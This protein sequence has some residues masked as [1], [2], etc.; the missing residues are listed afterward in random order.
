M[1]AKFQDY[2]QSLGLRR[3]ASAD[4]IQ[5]AYRTM[6]RKYHPDVSKEAGADAKFKEIS[7]A[8]E[9]LKDPEKRKR[10]DAL[11]ANWKQGQEFR[12]PPGW[13]GRGGGDGQ[14]GPGGRR[15]HVNFGGRGGGGA[16]FSEFFESIFGGGGMGGIDQDDFAEAMRGGRPG[17]RGGRNH[18]RSYAQAGRTQEAEITIPLADAFH[19]A[20]RRISLSSVDETGEESTRNYEVRIPA[21]VTDGSTIRLPGQGGEG[22]GGGPA[23]DLLLRVS[24]APDPRFR[25]DPHHKHNLHTTLDIAPWEAALGGRVHLTTIDGD[26]TVTIPAGSQSGQKLRIRARGLPTRSRSDAAEAPGRGDLFAELRIV[27]PRSLTDEQRAL[28]E[29]LAKASNFDPRAS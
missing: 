19:G 25:I 17:A 2:Y 3:G 1:T 13:G 4:E 9:V 15:V 12:P 11:G 5:S 8:Y 22:Y 6:A 7:E 26:I 18:S 27:T 28:W 16:D 14:G 10:Y 24:I 20:T 23:G 29:Q 21:G